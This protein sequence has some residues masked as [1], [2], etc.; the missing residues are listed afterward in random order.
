[1][2][3]GDISTV[4]F[5]RIRLGVGDAAGPS[6]AEGDTP[7]STGGVASVL[8]SVR[9]FAGEGDS[10]GVPVSSCDSTRAA[11]ML[12]PISRVI[13]SSFM[14]ITRPLESLQ[15]VVNRFSENVLILIASLLLFGLMP[16]GMAEKPP[17]RFLI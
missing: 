12:R 6:A 1:V 14:A 10:V 8:F 2:G 7:L 13:K 16:S 17:P 11:Q 15:V 3:L 5:L 9:C 4:V